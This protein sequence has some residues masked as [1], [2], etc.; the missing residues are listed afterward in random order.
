MKISFVENKSENRVSNFNFHAMWKNKFG[1][2][3]VWFSDVLSSLLQILA[4]AVL[5]VAVFGV[6]LPI[7][8]VLMLNPLMFTLWAHIFPKGT[9]DMLYER[10]MDEKQP[11]NMVDAWATICVGI[12]CW[13]HRRLHGWMPRYFAWNAKRHFIAEEPTAFSTEDV[14]RYLRTLTDGEKVAFFQILLTKDNG[15]EE[16]NAKKS[17]L[18]SS[19]WATKDMWLRN[20]YLEAKEERNE[21]LTVE[22]IKY[23]C[24]SANYTLL[25]AYMKRATLSE[26]MLKEML[27]CSRN[28]GAI[29]SRVNA[30]IIKHG[31]SAEFVA[32]ATTQGEA[33]AE[34]V[35]SDLT[36]YSQ[37]VMTKQHLCTTDEKV[38]ASWKKF[39]EA[40][41]TIYPEAQK[42]F[43]LRQLVIFYE[44]GHELS[45]DAIFH[46]F[47]LAATKEQNDMAKA[48]FRH[49]GQKA[50]KS[51]RIKT[52]VKTNYWL[53]CHALELA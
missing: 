47:F 51:E 2:A 26:E 48:I 16:R 22:E 1:P 10:P 18:L 50:L 20:P 52:L 42:E 39:C 35:D 31:V 6:A 8:W 14:V 41:P 25:D 27:P 43:C 12:I 46:F 40:T 30:H 9:A 23:I 3:L 7:M 21:K 44:T 28:D 19:I 11:N 24:E 32:W 37:I 34:L 15:Y 53:N 5:T 38:A 17:A 33:F 13:G 45:E 4:C 36:I 49:E 29:Q